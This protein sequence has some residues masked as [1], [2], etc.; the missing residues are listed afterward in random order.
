MIFG[1]EPGPADIYLIIPG[2]VP[3]PVPCLD[4]YVFTC[5]LDFVAEALAVR[6]VES[7]DA[8]EGATLEELEGSAAA[9]GYMGDALGEAHLLD[10]SYGVAAAHDAG[11][12]VAGGIA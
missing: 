9:G 1:P 11:S 2:M 6:I 7:S 10:G 12:A 4:D 5:F 8:G 3:V